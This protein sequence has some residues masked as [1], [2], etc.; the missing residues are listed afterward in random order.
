MDE[1]IVVVGGA[2]LHDGRLLAAR[3]S[4]PPSWPAAGS[5]PAARWNRVRLPKPP[6]YANCARNSASRRS[7]SSAS[8]GVAP[9]D[10][11]RPARV[12]RAAASRLGRSGASRGPRRPALADSGRA[13][14]RGLAGPGHPRREGRTAALGRLRR[15]RR[16]RGRDVGGAPDPLSC[17][18]SS[19]WGTAVFLG[20]AGWRASAGAGARRCVCGFRERESASRVRGSGSRTPFVPQCAHMC[21]KA[22]RISGMCPLTP[23]NQTWVGSWPGK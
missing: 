3:R 11:V 7:P 4:A 10:A 19:L 2:L 8:R 15:P 18:R 1:T 14:G 16:R 17:A 20:G 21:G 13:L 23:R 22:S 12:D 6:S 5:C 9:A